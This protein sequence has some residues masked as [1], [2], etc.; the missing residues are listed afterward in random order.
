MARNNSHLFL[1]WLIVGPGP[2]VRTPDEAVIDVLSR[3]LFGA[4][5]ASGST[6]RGLGG[7]EP[8]RKRLYA[9]VFLSIGLNGR[10]LLLM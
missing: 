5:S 3:L 8:A 1:D 4:A 7:S 2:V 10:V 9:Y 6:C